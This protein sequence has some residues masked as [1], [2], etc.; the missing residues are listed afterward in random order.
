MLCCGEVRG[1]AGPWALHGELPPAPPPPRP[2][3]GGT[4]IL[5]VGL[6]WGLLLLPACSCLLS[7]CWQSR[8]AQPQPALPCPG[9]PLWGGKGPKV[10]LPWPS[11]QGLSPGA[12]GSSRVPIPPQLALGQHQVWGWG[13]HRPW[14]ERDPLH[15]RDPHLE[16]QKPLPLPRSRSPGLWLLQPGCASV[17]LG[18]G[19]GNPSPAPFKDTLQV[20]CSP[21]PPSACP[22]PCLSPGVLLG[23]THEA[24][25]A[26]PAP[27]KAPL[28]QAGRWDAVGQSWS[29]G[30]SS[31]RGGRG[32]RCALA[33]GP[34]PTLSGGS[35]T[36]C[37]QLQNRAGG[38]Q[39]R[40]G[41]GNF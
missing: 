37:P 4:R 26:P 30:L 40:Y 7:C 36:P 23:G 8:E 38:C 27:C 21:L 41:T 18:E 13:G 11:P 12:G 10:P 2:G 6:A 29:L 19:G 16:E 20:G 14:V 35:R 25:A 24:L 32:P 5:G 22:L 1:A 39:G 17:S 9:S 15:R 33:A 31:S 34:G 28:E 3:T